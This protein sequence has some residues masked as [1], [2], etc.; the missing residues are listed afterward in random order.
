MAK[1]AKKKWFKLRHKI[2]TA[3]VQPIFHI[4]I[5]TKYH[6]KPTKFKD[7]KKRQYLILLNHQTGC[8]QFFIG[9]SFGKNVN[10][11]ASEDIFSNGFVSRLLTYAVAPI[12]IKKQMNDLGAI[13][14]AVQ[15]VKEGATIAVAPEGNRTYSGKTEYI[16]DSIT[17]LCKILKLPIAF[18]RIEG[19]YGV[20]P[21]WAD[22]TRKGKMSAYVS[23][24]LEYDEYKDLPNDQLFEIIKTELFVDET[25][26]GGEYNGKNLAE[27]LERVAYVCPYCGLTEFETKGDFIT[28]KT[29]KKSVRYL[30]DKTLEGEGFEFPFKYYKDWYFYQTEFIKNLD[31]STLLNEPVFEDRAKMSSVKLYKS[32]AV[33]DKKARLFLFG[34]RIE[35]KTKKCAYNFVFSDI[36]GVSVLGRN[37]LNVYHKDGIF[38]FK[39]EKSFNAV[40]YV[41]FYFRSKYKEIEDVEFLGL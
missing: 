11:I 31:L 17:G 7:G 33:L 1:K 14:N 18:Y 2:I 34:D 26:L 39:G 3:L 10:Y 12:P 19:G 6:F 41:N 35:V 15:A 29:C 22:K 28:C 21:R 25:K 23:K 16:K 36:S 24:V 9:R 32:K 4:Y 8:D 20:H 38:Q 5:K 27:H 13:R 30:P 40:K 37:K